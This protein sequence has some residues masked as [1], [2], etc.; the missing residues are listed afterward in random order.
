MSLLTHISINEIKS[1][2][3]N[4][5]QCM[6]KQKID[7]VL[8]FGHIRIFYFSG[9][10]HLPT[11]RPVVFVFTSKE[12][13]TLLVPNLE[14]ENI[15]ERTPHIQQIRVYREYPGQ[16]H[17]MYCLKE[18][19]GEKNLLD[20]RIGVDALGWG[21]GWGYRGPS[22]NEIGIQNEIINIKDEIDGMR[23]IKSEEELQLMRLSSYHGNVIHGLL[24][25]NIDIGLSELEICLSTDLDMARYETS[26]MGENWEPMGGRGTSISI[27]SGWKT[28]RNH[29]SPGARRIRNGDV[30]LTGTAPEIGGYMSELERT[31]IVG[32]PSDA[33]K[34]YFDLAT[35][36]QQ[37]AFDAIR[38]GRRCSDVE[39]EVN[40]F[41]EEKRIYDLTR[42]HIG[43]GIGTEGHEIPFLDLGDNT[44]IKPGMCLTVEPCLFI[45]GFAGF[46]HSDTVA[47]TSDGI[48]YIT[49]YTRDLD[50]LTVLR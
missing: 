25:P 4:L 10:H 50:E 39:F 40:K 18:I 29:R 16:K 27:T 9:F 8:L 33:Q 44:I 26:A 23:A 11:E 3:E 14:E 30:I 46:R 48:E 5:L 22:L 7:A 1:R 36:A 49:N 34:V 6:D 28:S 43:H 15:P 45:P 20:K 41:L 13:L 24:I 38:P 32:K 12:D 31:I 19:L 47:V 42:T 35:Q 2:Q 37:I 17:P 21:G